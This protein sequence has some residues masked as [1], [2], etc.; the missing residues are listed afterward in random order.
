M[1]VSQKNLM[2]VDGAV[3]VLAVRTGLPIY[4]FDFEAF[5]PCHHPWQRPAGISA[6]A[7]VGAFEDY[8]NDCRELAE[9][10]IHLIHSPQQH[11]LCCELPNW[12]PLLEDLTPRSKWYDLPP[13]PDEIA[14][15]FGWPVFVKG[16]RQTSQHRKALSVIEGPAE[17]N[18]AMLVYRNDPILKWQRIAC[19]EYVPLRRVG[20]PI[21]EDRIPSSFEFRTFWWKGKLVGFGRYWWEDDPY[22]FTAAEKSAALELSQKAANRLDVPFLVV[23]IAQTV[24]GKW[25]VIEC[26]DAQE[27]GYAGALPISIWQNIVQIEKEDSAGH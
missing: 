14:A 21:Q 8:E 23:D 20:K 3:W 11:F 26:N 15:E 9:D 7:R 19:R 5:L 1:I 18:E 25:I 17:F 24:A 16:V 6:I 22:S 13:E 4:D 10:G 2:L 27:S 12:Y